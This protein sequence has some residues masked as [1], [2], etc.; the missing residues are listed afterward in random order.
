MACNLNAA[1]SQGGARPS[2]ALGW[3]EPGRWPA[4]IYD[5]SS[6]SLGP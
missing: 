5:A 2:L 6:N 3:Y 1:Y 4:R